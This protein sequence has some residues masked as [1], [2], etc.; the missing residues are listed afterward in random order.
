MFKDKVYEDMDDI[1][2]LI[3]PY[4]SSVNEELSKLPDSIEVEPELFTSMY[5][6]SVREV[7]QAK[8][9]DLGLNAL[10][11]DMWKI[12][13]NNFFSLVMQDNEGEPVE[14]LNFNF[15][16]GEIDGKIFVVKN[17]IAF[18]DEDLEKISIDKFISVLNSFMHKKANAARVN[19]VADLLSLD[20]VK[21]ERSPRR[22]MYTLMQQASEVL[23]SKKIDIRD[24]QLVEKFAQW[25]KLYV[26]DGNL[27][28]LGNIAKIK[29]MSHDK[30]PIYSIQEQAVQ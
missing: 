24:I 1:S 6:T 29:I 20:K 27:P 25:I 8:C 2:K 3:E 26:T 19:E 15:K 30:R 21:A 7:M 16:T 17:K 22:K 11:N 12:C 5:G 14:S 10:V 23:R 18:E 4:Q 9:R 28:A 13:D